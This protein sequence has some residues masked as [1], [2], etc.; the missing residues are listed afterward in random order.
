MKSLH[1]IFVF[2]ILLS[3]IAAAGI[4]VAGKTKTEEPMA[5]TMDALVCPD[6]SSVGRTGP[7]CN[8][9]PC[10]TASA[11][12]PSDVNDAIEAKADLVRVTSPTPNGAVSSP[13]TITGEAR[14]QWFFEASCPISVVDWD[15]RIIGEGIATADGEWMTT[16]FVPFT[17][18]ISFDLPSDTPYERGAIILK[19][20]NPS[21][22][23]ENDDA[24]EIPIIFK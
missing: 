19:K 12:I 6:G 13:L 4:F 23:P 20:D 22:L 10:P 9:A 21:G 18:Q 7:D 14:G 24:L 15:G 3:V 16:E 5:C 1:Y 17:A 2:I 11:E 8:F